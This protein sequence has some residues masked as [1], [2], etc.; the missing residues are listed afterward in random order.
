MP[1]RRGVHAALLDEAPVEQV[2]DGAVDA[3]LLHVEEAGQAALALEVAAPGVAE[4]EDAR[5]DEQGKAG[6]AQVR[7]H[8]VPYRRELARGGAVAPL[9]AC[10]RHRR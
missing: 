7:H 4:A 3:A 6:E 8:E 1:A 5:V 10:G 2:A 9:R